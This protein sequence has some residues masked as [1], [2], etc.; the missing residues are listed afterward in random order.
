MRV[1]N[2]KPAVVCASVTVAVCATVVG[3]TA[4]DG[5]TAAIVSLP[6]RRYSLTITHEQTIVLDNYLQ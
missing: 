1:T 6:V 2:Y 5:S 3:V 4:A